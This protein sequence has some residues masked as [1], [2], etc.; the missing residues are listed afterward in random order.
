MSNPK[1]PKDIFMLCESI[2]TEQ[3]LSKYFNNLNY[4]GNFKFD[5]ERVMACKK[6]EDIILF[7]RRGNIITYKFS[8]VVKALSLIKSDFMIDGE[9]ISFDNDFTKLQSRALT[10]DKVKIAELE[11]TIPVKFM[12]FDILSIG[13]KIIMKEPLKQ[14]LCY[15]Q[16]L[17]AEN[18]DNHLEMCAYGDIKSLLSL[19]IEKEGEGIIV[20]DM[21]GS[22]ENKRSK[23]WYKYKLFKEMTIT[24][25]GFSDNP[26][27]IR[28]TDDLGNAV[29]I[30]G[31]QSN[32]VKQKL[33]QEGCATISVQY[34]AK[35]KDNRLRF[36]SFRGLING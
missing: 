12:I 28:A 24:I 27:G 17:L 25:T 1:E 4:K 16:E 30:A 36:P 26:K 23:N 7:N 35:T 11:K 10:K 13:E 29:Q 21:N 3:E 2:A 19:A 9:V 33:E 22:Y 31:F 5:G 14:R 8:E 20:K 6:G 32:E 18:K 15:L 34:L